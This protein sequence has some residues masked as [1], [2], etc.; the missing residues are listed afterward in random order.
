MIL[1]VSNYPSTHKKEEVSFAADGKGNLIDGRLPKD[2]ASVWQR[3]WTEGAIRF[4][5]EE[6]QTV[7]PSSPGFMDAVREELFRHGL[8]LE[9]EEEKA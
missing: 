2:F 3:I 4:W 7:P 8:L 9:I 6:L 1:R 5:N